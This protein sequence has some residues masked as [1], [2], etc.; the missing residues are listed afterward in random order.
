MEVGAAILRIVQ[1]EDGTDAEA[2]DSLPL[3]LRIRA[4]QQ[5]HVPPVATTPFQVPS[6]GGIFLNR[7]NHLQEVPVDRHNCVLE[8]EIDHQWVPVGDIQTQHRRKIG[9]DRLQL[10]GH[11]ANL[12]QPHFTLLPY[13]F[14]LRM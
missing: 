12:T 1:G 11:Q 3:G 2:R 9:H 8:P 4:L 5:H 10:L 14:L 7:G 13:V 6:G